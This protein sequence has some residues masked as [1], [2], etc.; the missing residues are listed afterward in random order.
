MY[1]VRLS[2]ALLGLVVVLV[3]PALPVLVLFGAQKLVAVDMKNGFK[4]GSVK[5]SSKTMTPRR[6]K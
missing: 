3:T 4:I 6:C 2:F 1:V 5:Q